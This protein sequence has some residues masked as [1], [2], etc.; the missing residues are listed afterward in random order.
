MLAVLLLYCVQIPSADDAMIDD[1]S[2]VADLIIFFS[3]MAGVNRVCLVSYF[4]T[5][6]QSSSLRVLLRHRKLV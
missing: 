5:R 4:Q 2:S 6:V 3:L 1:V